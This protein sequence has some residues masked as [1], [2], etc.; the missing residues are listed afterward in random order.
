MKKRLGIIALVVLCI[1]VAILGL[2]LCVALCNSR[3]SE[4]YK[5]ALNNLPDKQEV[6]KEL[7]TI[8]IGTNIEIVSYEQEGGTI[9]YNVK[10][11]IYGGY[12]KWQNY[13]VLY[14]LKLKEGAFYAIY[15]LEYESH[16][17]INTYQPYGN[18]FTS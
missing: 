5:T 6:S 9:I 13:K 18:E 14:K 10:V 2:S 4:S 11:P 17:Y 12:V 15:K 1:I 7:E 3:T 8:L 16:R